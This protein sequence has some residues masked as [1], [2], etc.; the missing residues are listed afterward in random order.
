MHGEGRPEGWV[1]DLKDSL[2][3]GQFLESGRGFADQAHGGG[4]L[5]GHGSRCDGPRSNVY[6]TSARCDVEP[7]VDP[8]DRSSPRCIINQSPQD[9]LRFWS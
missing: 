8:D 4:V 5:T 3:L 9:R 7:Q 1:E 6:F 2:Q